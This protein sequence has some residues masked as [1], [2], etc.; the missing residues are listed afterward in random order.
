VAADQI[1]TAAIRL[2]RSDAIR[3]YLS[4]DKSSSSEI[5]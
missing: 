5:T 4:R 1:L 3:L 2:E